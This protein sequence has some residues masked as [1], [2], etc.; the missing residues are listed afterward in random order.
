MRHDMTEAEYISYLANRSQEP[1][2]QALVKSWGP[3]S[4]EDIALTAR[5]FGGRVRTERSTPPGEAAA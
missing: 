2:I 3:P 5:I 4:A 1:D